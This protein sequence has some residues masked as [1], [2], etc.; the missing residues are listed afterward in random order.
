MRSFWSI[1]EC[2]IAHS[3]YYLALYGP[4]LL[5]L[6]T[7]TGG[8]IPETPMKVAAVLVGWGTPLDLTKPWKVAGL[9]NHQ[10]PLLYSLYNVLLEEKTTSD[11]FSCLSRREYERAGEKHPGLKN[12]WILR[13]RILANPVRRQTRIKRILWF[14]YGVAIK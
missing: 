2:V 13:P 12:R 9:S 3:Q 5:P 11:F 7:F 1:H 14:L 4:K 10:A 8:C 6:T